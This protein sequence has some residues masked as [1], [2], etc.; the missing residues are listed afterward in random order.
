MNSIFPISHCGKRRISALPVQSTSAA[1]QHGVCGTSARTQTRIFSRSY[2]FAFSPYR[3]CD[4]SYRK[5]HA[6]IKYSVL[7]FAVAR[8]HKT[9]D[10]LLVSALKFAIIC[11][12]I[13]CMLLDYDIFFLLTLPQLLKR[14]ENQWQSH[15]IECG[16]CLWIRK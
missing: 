3:G 4:E 14:R 6:Y 8:F 1:C 15:T 10:G 11:E 12:S 13:L 16:N 2:Y 7:R 9:Y 5:Y